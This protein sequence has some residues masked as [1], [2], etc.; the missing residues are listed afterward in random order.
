MQWRICDM[1]YD[2]IGN[3]AAGLVGVPP[4]EVV[5]TDTDFLFSQPQVIENIHNVPVNEPLLAS[6]KES[7]ILNPLLALKEWYPLA[8][9]QRLRAVQIIKEGDPTFNVKVTV[10]RFLEDW[11]NCFYLWP[12]I[13]FRNDAIA[14][15]FQMQE[16]VFKSLHYKSVDDKDGTKMTEYE[17]LGEELKWQHDRPTSKSDNHE[18]VRSIDK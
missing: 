9:S 4:Y 2:R 14:I 15:W 11:H 1:A 13:K 8:G 18:P 5:Y 6:V 16:V 7:G 12:D 10:H 3:T 17:R